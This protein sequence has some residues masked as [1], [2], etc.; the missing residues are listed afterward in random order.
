MISSFSILPPLQH[1]F[2]RLGD[3]GRLVRF[4]SA[5]RL[6]EGDL[7]IDV[8]LL[9]LRYFFSFTWASDASQSFLPAAKSAVEYRSAP[10]DRL[11]FMAASAD[12]LAL[13]ELLSTR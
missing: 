11:A 7:G 12:T 9:C 4:N 10:A 13:R 1:R 8:P 2:R 3:H 6:F 5:G